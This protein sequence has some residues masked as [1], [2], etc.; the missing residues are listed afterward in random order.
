MNDNMSEKGLY[1]DVISEEILVES[2]RSHLA[3]AGRFDYMSHERSNILDILCYFFVQSCLCFLIPV[4]WERLLHT[5]GILSESLEC[6]GKKEHV[7]GK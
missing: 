7:S 5:L 2:G 4:H 3:G 6:T 1:H